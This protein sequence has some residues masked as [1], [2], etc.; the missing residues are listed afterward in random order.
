MTLV[1]SEEHEELRRI[2]RGFFADK[3]PETEV[4]RV[5][6]TAEGYDAALWKQ[7]AVQL[8]LPGLAIGEDFGGSG[9][10][11]LALT[12]VF[13]EMGRTLVC[14]PY[15]STAAMAAT[16]LTVGGD[17]EA[18]RDYLPRI[19]AGDMVATVALTERGGRWDEA[20]ITM[21]ATNVDGAWSLT[22]EKTYVLDGCTA[23]L[24]LVVARTPAGPTVFAVE[25]S[26][27]G[28]TAQ[29]L[30]TLDQT[31][32]QARLVFDSTPARLIGVEG[33]GWAAVSKML[34]RAAVCLAAEQIGGAQRMLETT[35]EYAR[36]RA[37]FGRPIGSFQAIKHRCAELAVELE[38]ARATLLYASWVAAQD[39]PDLPVAASIA[40][41]RCS[42]V[43][44][45]MV[46]EAIQIHGAIGFTWE[47]PAQL[48]FKRAKSS[49]LLLG[50]PAFHRE[51]LAHRTGI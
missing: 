39:T 12:V 36:S 18:Q 35:L 19:A 24:I 45:R 17:A 38:A 23:Q 50:S 8:D 6:E 30:S 15:F 41:V 9:P 14:A 33:L 47:H 48:Y 31:R 2:L 3:S 51:L 16:L 49:E 11:P 46:L 20:G 27:G 29:P 7:M 4:R 26:A 22:G 13:E 32:K 5:M 21:S 10:D 42:E 25:A 43:Y 1:F 40:K 28:F 37:Q 34:D 44:F